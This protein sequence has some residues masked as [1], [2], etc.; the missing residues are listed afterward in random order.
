MSNCIGRRNDRYYVSFL[1][2]ASLLA[3]LVL[4]LCVAHLALLARDGTADVLR[5]SP[6][7]Y[8][9][10]VVGRRV[11]FELTRAVACTRARQPCLSLRSLLL[12]LVTAVGM[13][14]LSGLAC[15]HTY[16]ACSGQTTNEWVR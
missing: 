3:L 14:P 13:M 7:R 12:I 5:A 16:L 6:V 1:V 9:D 4:A 10:A 2:A 8:A 15:L 11:R